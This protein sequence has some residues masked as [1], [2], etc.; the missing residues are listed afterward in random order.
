MP[1]RVLESPMA[2]MLLPQL[3]QGMHASR[4]NGPDGLG[5]T[6]WPE[7]PPKLNSV[8]F[9]TRLLEFDQFL[10]KS[11]KVSTIIFFTSSTCPPCKALYPLYDQLAEHYGNNT[12][13]IKVD[14]NIAVDVAA[15]YEITA[16]PTFLG[17]VRGEQVKRWMGADPNKLKNNVLLLGHMS[18]TYHSHD[19]LKLASFTDPATRP[20]LYE[21]SPPLEKLFYKMGA[22]GLKPDVQALTGFVEARQK[23]EQ[24][25]HL[26]G[27]RS[28]GQCLR[29]AMDEMEPELIFTV[30]DLF[31]YGL[32]D[33]RM[34]AFYAQERDFDTI[35]SLVAYVN[36][37][38][39]KCVY[40]MRLVTLH[41][42]CN[43]FSTPLFPAALFGDE[44]LRREFT[45]MISS[46]FLDDSH[47]NTRVAASSL[48]FNVALFNRRRRKSNQQ[49]RLSDDEEVELAA[50][51]LEAI[52]QEQ[53]S[54]EALRGMLLS[55][56]HL[57][58]GM[59]LEGQ[60]ADL[61]RALDAKNTVLSKRK[62][63]PGEKLIREVGWELLET[64]LRKP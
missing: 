8:H 59:D 44:G 36:K 58:Y 26:P 14:I 53:E 21:R 28:L 63:F 11:R 6:A 39:P 57:V 50:S 15:K 4:V 34:S 30:V 5:E 51:L 40:S 41:T 17:L 9:P 23:N 7:E 2:R 3:T 24:N 54:S 45:T 25:P 18:A 16:T 29:A 13:F 27:L 10:E 1:Q 42:A 47:S 61:M 35:L 55:L 31:R 37:K 56:G 12:A 49:P 48:L 60:L 22:F 33:H 46:S 64:G 43:M 20:V 38:G 32:V 19:A 52:S 62:K